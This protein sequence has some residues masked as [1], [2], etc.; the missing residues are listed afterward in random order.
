LWNRILQKKVS[1]LFSIT[2]EVK[3]NFIKKPS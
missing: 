3:L 1:F 2:I